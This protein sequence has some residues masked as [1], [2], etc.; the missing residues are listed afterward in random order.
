MISWQEVGWDSEKPGYDGLIEVASRLTMTG[1]TNS[2]T[3]E[4]SVFLFRDICVEIEHL[5]LL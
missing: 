1:K 5:I 3:I 2:E 4:A